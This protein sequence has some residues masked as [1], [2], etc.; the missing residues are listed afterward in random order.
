M[1]NQKWARGRKNQIE[2]KPDDS[3]DDVDGR[4]VTGKCYSRPDYTMKGHIQEH[5]TDIKLNKTKQNCNLPTCKQG[6]AFHRFKVQ[7]K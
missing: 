7:G 6:K 2:I 5:S 3:A 4:R 1:E